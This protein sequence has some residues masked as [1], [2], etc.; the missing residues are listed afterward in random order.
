MSQPENK[1]LSG[2]GGKCSQCDMKNAVEPG[3][4]SGWRLSAASLLVFINPLG[5]AILGAILL[6]MFWASEHATFAGAAAGLTVGFIES[7]I[8]SIVIRKSG[9][10]KDECDK[11]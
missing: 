7:A 10:R 11:N 4:Y 1:K 6:P 8:I 5:M 9:N 3:A 2:C